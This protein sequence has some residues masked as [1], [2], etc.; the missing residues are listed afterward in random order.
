MFFEGPLTVVRRGPPIFTQS[1]GKFTAGTT[2]NITVQATIQPVR[3]NVIDVP[4][5]KRLDDTIKIYS[6]QP[7]MAADDA[8]GLPGDLITWEGRTYEVQ[9]MWDYSTQ[10]FLS[11][12]KAHAVLQHQ[13]AM[14]A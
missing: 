4:E 12:F 7:L 14:G 6:D 1:S 2:T 8:T 3:L 5:G 9:Q 10:P 11:H 13:G